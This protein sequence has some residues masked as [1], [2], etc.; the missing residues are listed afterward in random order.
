MCG[1]WILLILIPQLV[2]GTYLQAI[3]EQLAYYM[4]LMR[5]NV[6]S[7]YLVY[8]YTCTCMC[9]LS[10]PDVCECTDQES[11]D[12]CWETESEQ[13]QCL[14]WEGSSH[15]SRFHRHTC[16]QSQG[17]PHCPCLHVSMYHS[18]YHDFEYICTCTLYMHEWEIF[19][20]S[21]CWCITYIYMHGW[22]K[23]PI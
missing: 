22:E 2:Y 13:M 16:A 21:F 8:S 10:S 3:V 5:A 14:S 11:W 20:P 9:I 17:E 15:C 23:L 18:S 19:T 4:A 6:C 7:M 1:G 12:I